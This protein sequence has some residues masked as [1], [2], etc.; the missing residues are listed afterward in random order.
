MTEWRIEVGAEKNGTP[1]A[2]L[3]DLTDAIRWTLRQEE[4]G[5]IELSVA[6]MADD[7]IAALNEKYL[8]HQ[9]PTDVISFPLE[10]PGAGRVG[11]IYIGVDE[12]ERQAAE[13]GV[14]VREELIRLVIH[15]TLHVLGWEHPAD[16]ERDGTPMYQ[17]QEQLLRSFLDR[18]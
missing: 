6:L 17:R 13:H 1:A 18:S 14:T 8:S 10:R 11:D 5:E 7:S 4:V 3:E 15:G 12:A 16:D 9:G 2:L